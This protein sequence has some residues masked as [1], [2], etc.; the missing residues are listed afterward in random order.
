MITSFVNEQNLTVYILVHFVLTYIAMKKTQN[1]IHRVLPPRQGR[2]QLE[3][4]KMYLSY[5]LH[6]QSGI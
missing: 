3:S 4:N 5:I 6:L 1:L 2:D